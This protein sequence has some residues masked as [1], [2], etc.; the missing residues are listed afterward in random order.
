MG[1][2][3]GTF[4]AHHIFDEFKPEELG[5]TPLFFDHSFYCRKCQEMTSAKTCPHTKEDR[6]SLSG[7]KVRELLAAGELP[8]PEFTR[9]EISEILLEAYRKGSL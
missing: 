7:T 4:D 3:Y 2:Y 6:I 9:P 8:P 1:N 5:I